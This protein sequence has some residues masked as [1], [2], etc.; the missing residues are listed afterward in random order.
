MLAVSKYSL[1]HKSSMRAVMWQICCVYKDIIF[2]TGHISVQQALW[3]AEL[4]S[5]RARFLHIVNFNG[6][7]MINWEDVIM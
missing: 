6:T 4:I 2:S 1:D 3:L 5:V 7:G